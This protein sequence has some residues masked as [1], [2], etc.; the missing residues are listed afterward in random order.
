MALDPDKHRLSEADHQRIFDTQIRPRLFDGAQ[1]AETPVA[2]IF[3]G[4]PGAGKSAAMTAA[5]QELKTRGGA[6]E[7]IG[8]DLR[9]FHP[10]YMQLMAADDKTAAF[11][12]D[13]DS[14][15]WVEKAIAHASAQGYNVIIEGTF[16][17]N[18]VVA[19]TMQRFKA[20]GYQVDARALA[21]NDHFSLQGIVE[22][23]EKQRAD[24]GSGRM[25]TPDSHRAAYDGMPH[26][27][28]RIETE[29]LADRLTLYRRG[30]EPIY[31]NSLQA[32]GQWAHA[33]TG[34]QVLETERSRA[35]TPAERKTYAEGWE[36]IDAMLKAPG[37]NATAAEL[38]HV[39]QL[40]QLGQ[41][42]AG[43]SLVQRPATPYAAGKAMEQGKQAQPGPQIGLQAGQTKAPGPEVP[44]PQKSPSRGR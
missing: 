20:A 15:R 29:R 31:T 14:G 10:R 41:A 23:Y 36:R 5:G 18:E 4:Q 9:A 12:T 30:A 11:Y 6:V 7:I 22:R 2:V 35:W 43:M 38:Q 42:A 13:R 39:A 28:E 17:Q 19:Q 16:R 25:T 24:R 37:R 27:V 33:P 40:R 8:D 21:V 1:P 44:G 32:N 26:T 3:G 34:R